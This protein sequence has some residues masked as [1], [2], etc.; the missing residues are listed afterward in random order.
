RTGIGGWTFPPWRGGVFYPEGLRQADEL[1]FAARA[2]SAIEINATYY[3]RQK[4]ASFRTWRAAA[5][6]GFVFTL[7]GSRFVTNRKE[8]AGAGPAL[9]RFMDQGL[10]ELGEHLGPILWQL[11]ATKRFVAADVAAFLAMLPPEHEGVRLRH[12]IEVGHPSFACAE[13]V[14][15]ARNAGV[16][17]CFADAEA[18]T[19]IADRT[20]GFAYVRL[21]RMTADLATG[22]A[23]AELAR[24]ARLAEVWSQ[25]RAPAGLPYADAPGRSEQ[26]PGEVFV[27][28]IN[29]A[30][31]RAPAAAMALAELVSPGQ[32]TAG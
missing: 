20:A 7:K 5:P 15:L 11:M 2:V 16:A 29:G 27:F 26:A 32:R 22:Y 6:P 21:Q 24:Y 4:P 8:L 18:R 28:L 19:T 25:G 13:F 9:D 14:A 10:L 17:V 31:E 12:A 30:K 23:P 1:A 3:S